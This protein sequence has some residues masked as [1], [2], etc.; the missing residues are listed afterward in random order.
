MYWVKPSKSKDF[1][2]L[3]SYK[4]AKHQKSSESLSAEVWCSCSQPPIK[5]DH[6]NILHETENYVGPDHENEINRTWKQ[7]CVE[8]RIHTP[9][10]RNFTSINTDLPTKY[11]L[12]TILS[13]PTGQN[14]TSLKQ[15]RP[16]NV[17]W[18]FCRYLKPL[19]R[20]LPTNLESNLICWTASRKDHKRRRENNSYPFSLHVVSLNTSD[21]QKDTN[22]ILTEKPVESRLNFPLNPQQSDA[23]QRF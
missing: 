20:S 16:H 3:P 4:G 17:S 10:T 8:A 2:D 5:W 23:D 19:L 22:G 11:A 18:S 9:T 6:V 14:P 13:R 1:I 21:P 12:S 7:I 15:K